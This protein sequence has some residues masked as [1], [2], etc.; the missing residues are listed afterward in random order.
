MTKQTYWLTSVDGVK[1]SVDGADE[2]DRWVR[3][4]GWAV[5]DEPAAG[6]L[7][8]LQHETTGGRQVF[9][10]A[11]APQWEGLGWH[12]CAPPEPADLTKDPQLVDQA[13]AAA[14]TEPDKTTKTRAAAGAESKE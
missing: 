14:L 13:A 12:P 3:V 9:A 1:A 5:A 8:W 7:V 11:A 10:A 6:D 2:R 4:H